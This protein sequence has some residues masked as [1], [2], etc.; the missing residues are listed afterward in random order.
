[1]FSVEGDQIKKSLYI[2]INKLVCD[3]CCFEK[4]AR[5]L[6][7][8]K[9]N[10]CNVS[11]GYTDQGFGVFR[12]ELPKAVKGLSDPLWIALMRKWCSDLQVWF[13]TSKSIL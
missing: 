2:I 13:E 12:V 5:L 7:F 10:Q 6:Y 4:K 8:E 11:V 9:V 3:T 1:M